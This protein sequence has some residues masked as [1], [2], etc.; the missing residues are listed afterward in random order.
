MPIAH[1]FNLEDLSVIGSPGSGPWYGKSRRRLRGGPLGTSGGGVSAA[2]KCVEGSNM[3]I[4][5]AL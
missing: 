1:L 3:D 5:R 4:I 2:T